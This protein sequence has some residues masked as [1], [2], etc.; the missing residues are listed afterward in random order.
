MKPWSHHRS[1]QPIVGK[2]MDI[3]ANCAILQEKLDVGYPNIS[4][5]IAMP[6]LPL[7]SCFWVLMLPMHNRPGAEFP[8]VRCHAVLD[9]PVRMV[10]N[11]LYDF[12]MRNK[13]DSKAVLSK[14]SNRS[15]LLEDGHGGLIDS[16]KKKV[17]T[18]TRKHS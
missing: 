2:E 13:W 15:D 9:F 14:I 16:C 4:L 12:T 18:D 6:S 1:V 8:M 5:T 7:L 3:D 17:H 10:Y 11:F